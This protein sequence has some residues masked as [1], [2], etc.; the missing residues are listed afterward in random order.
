VPANTT[1]Q[2]LLAMLLEGINEGRWTDLSHLYADDAVVEQPLLAP[3]PGRL[4]GREQID[5]HFSAAASGPIRLRVRDLVVHATTDPEVVIAEYDYEVT[6]T[7]T[8]CTTTVANI[9]VLRGRDGKIQATR[10]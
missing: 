5:A 9:Q 3:T 8:G 2:D 10:D 7:V 1:P 6:H 4:V